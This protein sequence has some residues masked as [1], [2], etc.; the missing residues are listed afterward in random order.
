MKNSSSGSRSAVKVVRWVARVLGA[1]LV[2][3]FLFFFMAEEVFSPRSEPF[4]TLIN[5]QLV[6]VVIQIIGLVVAWKWELAGGLMTLA[7][8]VP[9]GIINLRT[10][11][12][13]WG[14]VPFVAILFLLCWWFSRAPG[15]R[16]DTAGHT[17]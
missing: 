14:L 16:A 10:L 7:A 13:L 5:V 15:Q 9:L 11:T 4:S 3:L 8:A 1:L 12:T 17:T 6:L 2:L